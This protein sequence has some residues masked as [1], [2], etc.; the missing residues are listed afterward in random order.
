M[1][2]FEQMVTLATSLAPRNFENQRQAMGSW[3]QAG[4][5]V[6]SLNAPDEI[7]LLRHNF[8][9]IQFVPAFRDGRVLHG[10][11]YV[12]FDDFMDYFRNNPTPI[13]GIV[14][15]DIHLINNI[16]DFVCNHAVNSLVFGSRI[17]VES[18][19][20]KAGEIYSGGFDFFFFDHK[21]I[22]CYPKEE[23]CIGVPW[24]DYWIVLM[25]LQEKILIK[26]L[27]T[28]IALHVKHQFNWLHSSHVALYAVIKKHF[29][30]PLSLISETD[31]ANKILNRI[32]TESV[33]V[34]L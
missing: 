34:F 4:F 18:L 15:S 30:S 26:R 19:N 28:P 2:Y 11:P 27:V 13:C 7:E 5:K 32:N 29:E 21:I 33:A 8:P 25:P 14:N 6:V 16:Y 10:K 23:F 12:Y 31:L 22:N 20:N 1:E 3:I 17:D 24:W 9:D